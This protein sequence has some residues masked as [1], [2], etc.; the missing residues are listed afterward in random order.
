MKKLLYITVNSK[1]EEMSTSR[2][3][4]R[5]FVNRFINKNGDYE[6]MELDLYKE[7]IPEMNYRMIKS[8]A[9]LV[10][11]KDYDFLNYEDK[12]AVDRT[13][14]LCN[15]FI[16]ADTYVI[17]SPMWSLSFPSPL[18]RYFDCII[19]NN[20]V[21]KISV[22]EVKGL[23]DDKERNMIYIQSSGGDY[24]MIFGAKFNHGINYCKDIF[25][26]L[27]IQRFE[28]LMVEGVDVKQIGKENAIQKAYESMD[29][30]ID[31]ISRQV[32]MV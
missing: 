6:V 9:E 23:L 15:Q 25:T 2:T 17:A 7:Y 29:K 10:S 32:M 28:K 12:K 20:K 11:G 5:E 4:G 30:L 31:R 18:K 24:P 26:F 16:S 14:I 8:R 1:P 3:V 21:I 22:D 19:Q 27:G 13:N